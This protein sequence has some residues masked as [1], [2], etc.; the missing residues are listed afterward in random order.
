M[1]KRVTEILRLK[2]KYDEEGS[3]MRCPPPPGEPSLCNTV[4]ALRTAYQVT[5]GR[6]FPAAAGRSGIFPVFMRGLPGFSNSGGGRR[7]AEEART[8]LG[9]VKDIWV[10]LFALCPLPLS[11]RPTAHGWRDGGDTLIHHESAR[12][13]V[14]RGGVQWATDSVHIIVMIICLLCFCSF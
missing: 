1:S 13:A 9:F 12:R 6:R 3:V 14:Q 8:A 2:H 10:F 11:A 7:E 4:R 5:F